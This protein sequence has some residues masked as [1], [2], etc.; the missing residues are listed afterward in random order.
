[1]SHHLFLMCNYFFYVY[2][3]CVF[4]FLR[5]FFCFWAS[6]MFRF[7]QWFAPSEIHM[8]FAFC[9]DLLPSELCPCVAFCD[10][11]FL[12]SF[13]CISLSVMILFL[14]SFVHVFAF[15]NDLAPSEL[16]ACFAFCDDLAPS[17]LH[18]CF[19][20][21]DETCSF[22][23][24]IVHSDFHAPI[25]FW[26]SFDRLFITQRDLVHASCAALDSVVMYIASYY[27]IF[28]NVIFLWFVSMFNISLSGF[29]GSNTISVMPTPFDS[30]SISFSLSC[31]EIK[32][33][34]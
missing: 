6:H 1:M 29:I 11:L 31:K 15:F 19:A 3:W 30:R 4:R 18:A 10:D 7:L 12:L 28:S 5:W 17:E 33:R 26:D 25:F 23:L 14:L 21:Y 32:N 2:F 9:D 13:T 16:C 22:I 8:C 20:F 27:W 24:G 34:C